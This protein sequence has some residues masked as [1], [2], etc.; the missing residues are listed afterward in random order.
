VREAGVDLPQ[1]G[2]Q[3]QP[4]VRVGGLTVQKGEQ[5]G[6]CL[7]EA[8][9]PSRGTAGEL[10]GGMHQARV[11]RPGQQIRESLPSEHLGV[12]GRRDQGQ[13]PEVGLGRD[14]PAIQYRGSRDQPLG[15]N[16]TTVA[17]RDSGSAQ[18]A[19]RSTEEW[20][21]AGHFDRQSLGGQPVDGG[22]QVS[23]RCG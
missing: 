17:Q 21:H 2:L 11:A 14:R 15:S 5:L 6:T 16:S 4:D 7:A 3:T 13:D 23:G 12:S 9:G 18:P 19:D 8:F 22:Q 10:L 20:A 1:R